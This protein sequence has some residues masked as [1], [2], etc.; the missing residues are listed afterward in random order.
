MA[1]ERIQKQR[2]KGHSEETHADVSN[3]D[4]TNAELAEKT[5]QVVADIDDVL[6]DQLDDEILADIDDILEANAEEFVNNFVQQ[7]GE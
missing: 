5:S 1:Q 6:E 2:S 7:G 4:A 3:S